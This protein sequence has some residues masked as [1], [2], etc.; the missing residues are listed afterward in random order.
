MTTLVAL[1]QPAE[2]AVNDPNPYESPKEISSPPTVK[3]GVAIGSLLLLSIPAGCICGSITCS[4]VEAAARWTSEGNLIG[5]CIGL[6]IMVLVPVLAV[7]IFGKRKLSPS[8][9]PA[10]NPPKD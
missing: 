8:S 9:A 5:M 7:L 10:P 2:L 4:S 6:A 3:A 1:V